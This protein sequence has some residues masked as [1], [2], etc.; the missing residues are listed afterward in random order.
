MTLEKARQLLATQAG[1]GGGYNRH[2][3]RLILAEVQREHGP[4]AADTLI[5]E[6]HLDEVFGL[7]PLTGSTSHSGKDGGQK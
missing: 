2:G 5:R 6:L 4:A 3:A 7:T 1:F